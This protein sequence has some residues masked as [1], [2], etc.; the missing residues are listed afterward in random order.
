MY[1]LVITDFWVGF[2]EKTED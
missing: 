2:W 1:G